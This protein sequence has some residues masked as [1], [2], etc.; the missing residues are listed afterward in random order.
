M[1]IP[2]QPPP[3][4]GRPAEPPEAQARFLTALFDPA[5]LVRVRLIETWTGPDG[6]KNGRFVH[7]ELRTVAQL[8]SP[9]TWHRLLSIAEAERANLF[10]GVCPRPGPGRDK[11]HHI[12]AVR[13]LWADLDGVTVDEALALCRRAGLPAPSLV[14]SSGHGVH[15]YWLLSEPYAIDDYPAD[16]LAEKKPPL[17]PKAERLQEVVAGISARIGGDHTQ[18][19]SRLLR[20]P[21]TLNRKDERNGTAPVPCELAECDPGRLYPLMLFESFA[22]PAPEPEAQDPAGAFG[23]AAGLNREEALPPAVRARFAELVREC[24]TAKDRSRADF[25]VCCWAI[26]HGIDRDLVYRRLARLGKTAERG[27][28]YFD[29]TWEAAEEEVRRN[30]TPAPSANGTGTSR[31][32]RTPPPALK[33]Y[34]LGTLTLHP[35]S[36]RRTS[37]K[38]SVA[39]VVKDAAGKPIGRV[40][41]SDSANGQKEAAKALARHAPTVDPSP[42]VAAILADAADA[43]D[44]LATCTPTGPAIADVLREMVP[45]CFEFAFRCTRGAFSNRRGEEISAADFTQYVPAWLQRACERAVDCPRRDNREVNRLLLLKTM[46]AELRGLWA[47]IIEELPTEEEANVGPASPAAKRFKRVMV[48][49]LT[50][51]VQFEVEKS[52]LGT[53]ATGTVYASRT[54]IIERIRHQAD[55]YLSGQDRPGKREYWRRVQHA[56]DAWWRP[57]LLRSG[58]VVI[59]IACRWMIGFQVHRVHPPGV[60]DQE[61]FRKQCEKS[62]LSTK[63]KRVYCR[64]QDGERLVPLAPRFTR[65]L[66]ALPVRREQPETPPKP[67]H[68]ATTV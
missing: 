9:D 56:F 65:E 59:L 58:K 47:S 44:Q 21:G 41:F 63:L 17:S 42:A 60:H 16:S 66:M 64:L 8:L 14:V 4:N 32:A 5:D 35:E 46:S 29:D 15:L 22:G 61:S 38:V 51:G 10:F 33:P 24:A 45:P 39:V 37:S 31:T 19:L 28:G 6:K 11:A 13:G 53:G 40:S 34:P 2:Q 52:A 48:E 54:N 62:G 25:N 68:P 3:V 36:P 49:V 20:L 67:G 18:D 57:A 27:Q 30:G 12:R 7:A 1:T 23:T 50:S 26:R 43:A 55:P